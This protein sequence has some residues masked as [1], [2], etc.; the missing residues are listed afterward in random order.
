MEDLI[1]VGGGASGLI[2]AIFA[3]KKGLKV[4]I[5][6]HKDRIGKKILA[7]GNGKCNFTNLYMDIGCFRSENLPFVEKVLNKFSNLE[8]IAFFKSLGIYPKDIKGYVYPNSE[9]ALSLLKVLELEIKHLGVKVLCDIKVESISKSKS[10]FLVHT[11]YCNYKTRKVILATCG[12][13]SKNLGSDGSG[14]EIAKGLGHR[15][16]HP[17]P[18]MVQLRSNDTYFHMVAGVRSHA[19]IKLYSKDELLWKERGELQFTKYG[20]SG[21]PILQLSRFASKALYKSQKVKLKIDFMPDINWAS[22]KEM[23]KDRGF[24]TPYKN[25]E[26]VFYG[27]FN[28]KLTLCLLKEAGIPKDLPWSDLSKKQLNTLVS[29]IKS[30][31]VNISA[32][33]SF[34]QS[35]VTAGGVDTKEIN[36]ETME[37]KICKNLYF[38][39]EIID[40]DGTCGGYNLQWAWSSGFVAGSSI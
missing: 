30:F 34:D 33:N 3:A 26:E 38:C 11:N 7:T 14:F 6:E 27:L 20:V 22:L 19:L 25:I 40:V 31:E 1:I 24:Q 28:N 36:P 4:T 13:S 32:T 18:A 10:G 21:I 9:Q 8:T 15:I 29:K 16:I 5:L 23:L 39:G 12:C 2:A 35:Q 37:S 17:L